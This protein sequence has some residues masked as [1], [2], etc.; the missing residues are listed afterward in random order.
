MTA[1]W[2][3][4]R[5]TIRMSSHK[6]SCS[7]FCTGSPTCLNPPM[8]TN[9]SFSAVQHEVA[10]YPENTAKLW[11]SSFQC[12]PLSSGLCKH[13]RFTRR[14]WRAQVTDRH[15][16]RCKVC[17]PTPELPQGMPSTSQA[18]RHQEREV[19]NSIE[20]LVNWSTELRPYVNLTSYTCSEPKNMFTNLSDQLSRHQRRS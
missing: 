9:T 7:K 12:N 5:S 2:L 1:C 15:G 17:Q 3:S 6:N 8:R 16:I 19:R 11:I 4:K 10:K 20:D 14:L 13:R 18:Q